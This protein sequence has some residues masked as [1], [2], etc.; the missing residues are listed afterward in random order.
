LLDIHSVLVVWGDGETSDT[1]HSLSE[2]EFPEFDGNGG[3]A[4]SFT[5]R[6]EYLPGEYQ[7]SIM[8]RD[9]DQGAGLATVDITI[10]I[11]Q[12]ATQGELDPE[13]ALAWHNYANPKDIN[14]DGQLTVDEDVVLVINELNRLSIIDPLGNLPSRPLLP[15]ALS[16]PYFDVSGDNRLSS[17][18][19]LLPLLNYLNRLE[20][21]HGGAASS[22]FVGAVITTPAGSEDTEPLVVGRPADPPLLRTGNDIAD[23]NRVPAA[24]GADATS[25]RRVKR[26]FVEAPGPLP[27][28]LLDLLAEDVSR[29]SK[30]GK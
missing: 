14:G 11:G 4:G 16:P 28:S 29:A 6:H 12:P 23:A 25:A 19:D 5:A 30:Q 26:D 22:L 1:T 2:L 17:V 15:A 3:G 8:V 21:A 27:D 20:P 24:D 13:I 7:V 10:P 9:D 18:H